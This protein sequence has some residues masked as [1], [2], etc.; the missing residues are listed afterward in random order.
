M[1]ALNPASAPGSDPPQP[2]PVNVAAANNAAAAAPAP[3]GQSAKA[4][5]LPTGPLLFWLLIQVGALTLAAGRV[6]LAA[7]YPIAGERYAL[8]LLLAVQVGFAAMLFPWLLRDLSTAVMAIA[9]CWPALALAV[10]LSSLK[11]GTLVIAGGYLTLWLASLTAWRFALA[12]E[13]SQM[14]GTAVAATWAIGGPVVWYLRAEFNSP[15]QSALNP[16]PFF[17]P[18]TGALTQIGASGARLSDWLVLAMLF[19]LGCAA[20]VM[21]HRARSRRVENG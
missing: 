12:N 19:F 21:T 2:D 8:D 11:P 5:R 14:I 1:S 6:P 10:M 7:R 20:T 15:M 9:S 4:R 3:A 16:G 18:L 17:G 13:K